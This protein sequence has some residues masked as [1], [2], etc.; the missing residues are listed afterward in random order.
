[1]VRT[2]NHILLRVIPEN[3]SLPP[4][5]RFQLSHID[6]DNDKL[7]VVQD[8]QLPSYYDAYAKEA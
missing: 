3:L 7:M 6:E 5:N 2:L 8:S 1:M 4:K